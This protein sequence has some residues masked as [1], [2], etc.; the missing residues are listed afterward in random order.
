MEIIYK[1]VILSGNNAT[2]TVK[3]T[4]IH[5]LAALVSY[6]GTNL[7]L[8]TENEITNVWNQLRASAVGT[9]TNTGNDL[10]LGSG[11]NMFVSEFGIVN[12]GLSLT[13]SSHIDISEVFNQTRM[14]F[15]YGRDSL[16]N[17]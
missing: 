13:D 4:L 11:M 3:Y 15:D 14:T 9:K 8:Y 17:T 5:P 7:K 10:Y 6:D 2:D 16:V 12:S 1:H